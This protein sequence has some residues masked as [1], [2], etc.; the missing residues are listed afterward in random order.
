VPLTQQLRA[1]GLTDKTLLDAV[2]NE[3]IPILRAAREALNRFLV[4]QTAVVI[5]SGAIVVDWG[6]L[7][8]YTLALS[9]NISAISFTDPADAGWYALQV[10]QS[11]AFTMAGWPTNVKWAGGMA[12]TI[13]A[14][15]SRVDLLEFYFDGEGYVGRALQDAS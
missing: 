10:T 6:K 7:R 15:A 5:D 8:N 4:P 3:I 1:R 9:E 11:A 13:T 14:T 2:N 12:P